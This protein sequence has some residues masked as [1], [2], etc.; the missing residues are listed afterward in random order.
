[1]PQITFTPQSDI[2]LWRSWDM[3]DYRATFADIVFESV[4]ETTGANGFVLNF[5]DATATFSGTG[6][7]FSF[8]ASGDPSA[9]TAGTITGLTVVLT[10]GATVLSLTDLSV[11]GTAFS[12]ALAGED[13]TALFNLMIAGNDRINAGS[14]ADRLVGHL[15][16]DTIHG[17]GGN[18]TLAGEAG[19]DRLLGGAGSDV[20]IGGAGRDVMVGGTGRDTF[21]FQSLEDM[22]ATAGRADVISDF[23]PGQDRI[24]LRAIDAFAGTVGNDAFLWIGTAGF[25]NAGAGEVRYR[26]VDAAGT[27]DDHTLVLI[28][29]DGDRATEAVI[30]LTG[31]H[32]LTA[33]DF[34]L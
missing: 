20:L 19:A 14:G 1:M 12:R 16:N 18:D 26:K 23:R 5:G 15:G 24:D 10:G 22:A 33:A 4:F 29:V 3:D 17:G 32:D 8:D 6:L 7:R 31:L 27:E 25:G 2:P 34:L 13:S 28:D 11:A 21:V 9:I 30:R